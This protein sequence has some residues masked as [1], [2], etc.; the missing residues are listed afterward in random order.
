L[1]SLPLAFATGLDTIPSMPRYLVTDSARRAFWHRRLSETVRPRVGLAWAGN[2][3]FGNDHNRSIPLVSLAT[4]KPDNI[5]LVS[6]Q[7]EIRAS[8]ATAFEQRDDIINFSHDLHDFAD[9]AALIDELD[10]VISVDTAVA[11]LAGALG[12]QV[13]LLLPYNPD[14]R[15][16][17]KHDD[18]PWYPSA[19]LFRQSQPDDWQ[20]VIETLQKE[21]SL[22][23]LDPAR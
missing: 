21:I 11:H 7:K 22:F 13:W 20:S 6:L 16:L 15:W 19:R 4:F 3:A 10:L 23:R 18:S 5:T 9:T 12:K 14:W 2:V 17:L 1:L 8:D